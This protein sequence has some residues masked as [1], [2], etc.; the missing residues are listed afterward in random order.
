MKYLVLG[1]EGQIGKPL[2]SYLRHNGHEAIEYDYRHDPLE[3]LRFLHL[4][5]QKEIYKKI[6]RKRFRVFSC[7]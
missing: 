6:T 5:R 7:L 2:V 3:D 1:S 4:E